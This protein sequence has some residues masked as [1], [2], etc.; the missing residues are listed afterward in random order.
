MNKREVTFSNLITLIKNRR[1]FSILGIIFVFSS[2]F[3]ILPSILFM[4]NSFIE[5]YEKYNF[6]KIEQNGTE[7]NA[8][9][10]DLRPVNNV[11]INGEHPLR[12][13]YEYLEK[14]LTKTDKFQTMELEK[15]NEMK[16]GNEIK[17][18]TF[19]NQSKIQ[20]L[21]SFTFP[22]YMF[23][24]LP[25]IFFIIGSIFSFI[26]LTP[27]LLDYNL[28]KNGVVKDATLISMVPNSGLPISGIGQSI[29]INYYYENRNGQKIFG[30]SK[31]MDFSI[32]VEKKIEDKIKIFVSETDE[33]KSCL[34][35]KLESMKNNWKI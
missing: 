24:I 21:E 4:T 7:L 11:T 15:T 12:I 33:T 8:K 30:K 13:S 2:L 20:N 9:I 34:V 16:I 29:L 32:M 5:P 18:K 22:F 27:A 3:I 19:E 6:E 26:G 25:L 23:Y 14:G 28:Y 10:T 31:T 17:I 35:P 1:P